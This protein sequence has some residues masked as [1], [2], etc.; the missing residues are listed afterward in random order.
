MRRSRFHIGSKGRGRRNAQ[1]IT[2]LRPIGDNNAW[3]LSGSLYT[4]C[5]E[6]YNYPI[7]QGSGD[8]TLCVADDVLDTGVESKWFF[9]GLQNGPAEFYRIDVY[10]RVGTKS[11]DSWTNA[12]VIKGV[13]NNLSVSPSLSWWANTVYGRWKMEDFSSLTADYTNGPYV[14]VIPGINSKDTQILNLQIWLYG[15]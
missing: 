10:A 1:D 4:K 5:N 11:G 7:V 2:I 9:G 13:S 14:S 12:L 8:L 6:V 15:V 3:S